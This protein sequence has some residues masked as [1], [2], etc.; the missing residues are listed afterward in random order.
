MEYKNYKHDTYTLYTIKTDK[1]KTCHLEIIFKNK[2]KKEEITLLNLLGTY[3][4]YTSQEY[5]KRRDVIEAL[6]D[7]Y[8]A[9]FY[10]TNTRVGQNIFAT[11]VM[12]FLDPVYCQKSFLDDVLAFPFAFIFNPNFRNTVPDKKIF[13]VI[14]NMIKSSILSSKDSPTNYAFKQ[15]FKTLGNDNPA[16][17]DM[18]GDLEILKNITPED[19]YSYYQRFLKEFNCDIYIIGNL[20]MEYVDMKIAE[21]YKNNYVAPS[22]TDYYLNYPLNKKI[23]DKCEMGPY[24]QSSFIMLYKTDMLSEKEKNYVIHYFNSIF[25]SGSLNN[26]LNQYLREDN[27]LCYSTY[28]AYQKIDNLFIVYAGIDAENKEACV[29][30]VKKALKEMQQGKFAD[31]EITFA[32]ENLKNQIKLSLDTETSILDNYVFHNLINSPLLN[33]RIK[34]INNV[35]KDEIVNLSKKIKLNSI[36]LLGGTNVKE[37]KN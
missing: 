13:E 9:N 24:E 1:F 12:D 11:F 15:A 22:I 23:V 14:V 26:K 3:L 5:P 4:A 25:G 8:D 20:D 21:N 17:F 30:L 29:K 16:G 31:E 19:L 2:I 27:G 37:N 36:Y 10:E 34:E 32:K 6:E 7:L 28:S 35:T 33:E 18:N